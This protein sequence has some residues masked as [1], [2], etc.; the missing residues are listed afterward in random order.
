MSKKNYTNYHGMRETAPNT[1]VVTEEV[2]NSVDCSPVEEVVEEVVEESTKPVYGVV[3]CSKL[4][5]R[6][7]PNKAS[8]PLCVVEAQTELLI[9]MDES[10]VEWYSVTTPNGVEGFCMKQFITVK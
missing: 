5:V 1:D 7:K 10:T 6:K 2:D 4:N 9:D 3:N 8:E